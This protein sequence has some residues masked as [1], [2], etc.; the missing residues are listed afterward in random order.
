MKRY[1]WVVLA[2]MV[3]LTFINY[4]D[5][6]A[7]SIVAP[8]I[9]KDFGLSPAEMGVLFSAFF[10]SYALFCFVGGYVSDF[11]GPKKTITIALLLW[12]VFAAAPAVAWSFVSLFVVRVI[13]GA[14]EGP[15]SS[16]TNKMINNWFPATERAKAK[17]ITDT[18]MSL[19]AALAGPIVGL[20]AVE[21]GWRISFVTLMVLG[22][23][24]VV[25]WQKMVTDSPKDHPKVSPEELNEIES[26]KLTAASPTGE[27][28]PLA[29][30]IKQPIILATVVAFFATNYATYFFLTWFPS[31]LVMAHNLS[32]KNMAIVSVIPWLFGALGYSSGGFLS[33]YL[34]KRLGDL[35][36]A[37]KLVI[38]ICLAGAAVS[39]GMCGLVTTTTSAVLLM[40]FGIF[41]AYLATPS[42]WAIIQDS[43]AGNS[44]GRVGGFVHFLSNTAGIF[45]PSI[46]GFTVQ[47]S[48]SFVG[49][50]F[51]TGGLAITGAILVALFA[52]P[53]PQFSA[54]RSQAQG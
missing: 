44:V 34:V 12:S 21:F 51:L 9:M 3:A 48:G 6:A 16:V 4:I 53:I 36:K 42:Y 40:S 24:W 28:V 50:F 13:F 32:I 29:Y 22:L 7:L 47:A 45:A 30:Y 17:G 23:I 5:R 18:G 26:G 37:R 38:S 31:Y 46:T 2:L 39:I 11:W 8:Y 1:R 19:G 27:K 35:V 15:V 10:M 33:D 54:G 41:F 25:F 49:A 20:V 43:V 14:G 52:R